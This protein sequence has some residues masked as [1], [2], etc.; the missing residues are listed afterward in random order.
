MVIAPLP[1]APAPGRAPL[2]LL[3]LLS[4]PVGGARL[5]SKLLLGALPLPLLLSASG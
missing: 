1:A 5:L 2:L 4:A 3:L